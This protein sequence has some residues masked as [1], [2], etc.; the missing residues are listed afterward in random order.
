MKIHLKCCGY[1]F[2][3]RFVDTVSIR[4]L[5]IQN[6]S[7]VFGYSFHQRFVDTESINGVVDAVYIDDV[8]YIKQI[9]ESETC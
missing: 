1:R 5:W 6:P 3:Q 9:V 8:L 4:G 2:H 7:E